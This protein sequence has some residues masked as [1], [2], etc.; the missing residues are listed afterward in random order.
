MNRDKFNY[1][2]Q[3]DAYY[4]ITYD[5]KPLVYVDLDDFNVDLDTIITRE[6]ES[7]ELNKIINYLLTEYIDL[8]DFIF[9]E[10]YEKGSK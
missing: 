10:E 2:Y 7:K 4:L 3:Q 9:I 1:I 8:L 5:N 6:D